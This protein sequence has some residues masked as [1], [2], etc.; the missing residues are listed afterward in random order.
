MDRVLERSIEGSGWGN[1]SMPDLAGRAA[2]RL[3]WA[4]ADVGW[5]MCV[6]FSQTQTLT[7]R[8]ISG[9]PRAVMLW[10]RRV[11][12]IISDTAIGGALAAFNHRWPITVLAS[13][14]LAAALAS[15]IEQPQAAPLRQA[16]KPTPPSVPVLAMMKPILTPAPAAL[17]QRL[18]ALAADYGED[19]GIAVS[20][21]SDG[22]VASVRGESPFPQQ[23]VSKLWVAMTA[24]DAVDQGRMSL[25]QEVVLW[26]SDT[27]VF[28]QPISHQITEA[29]YRT[30]VGS[31]MRRALIGSD[32]AANDK[33]M[34][35]VG[36][37]SAIHGMLSRK[38]VS[39]IALAEDEKHLQARII[40]LTWSQDLSPY[41]AFEAARAALPRESRDAAMAAYLSNPYD[42]ASPRGIVA[43]LAAL[44]RGELLSKSS[45]AVMLETMAKAT[46]GPRR[47]RGGLPQGWAIAHKTGTGQ[48]FR[49]SSIGINDV[50]LITA[51]DGRTYAVAVL[52][53][54]TDKPNP[55]RMEF[56]QAVSR[57]VV[58]AWSAKRPKMAQSNS[59]NPASDG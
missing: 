56:M 6:G 40:G 46:T 48:D 9:R 41:G 2:A 31:L 35:L 7:S 37:P 30:T 36:G 21:V 22:W 13:L 58:E 34:A 10:S 44:H 15:Q 8:W 51:P 33:L 28:N 24:L 53:R 45:T 29:G 20:D 14:V 11:P 54:R 17:Q 26:P 52:M 59:G 43:A 3:F 18:E 57:A 38:A 16:I 55:E 4:A 47:L 42:G 39:G 49:G 5:A 25:E 32:N 12:D 23:S 19:V 27:S 50:G 1:L